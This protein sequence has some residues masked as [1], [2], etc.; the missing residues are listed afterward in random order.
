MQTNGAVCVSDLRSY[1]HNTWATAAT[2]PVY[3]DLSA[4]SPEGTLSIRGGG[5]GKLN[6]T[7]IDPDHRNIQLDFPNLKLDLR[8][9]PDQTASAS[10]T[11]TYTGVLTTGNSLVFVANIPTS[12]GPSYHLLIAYEAVK[13][14][15]WQMPYFALVSDLQWYLNSTPETVS[16]MARR[17]LVWAASARH[18]PY[19]VPPKFRKQLPDGTIAEVTAV[20]FLNEYPFC[21]WDGEGQ[22]IDADQDVF[23]TQRNLDRPAYSEIAVLGPGGDFNNAFPLGRSKGAYYPNFMM[24]GDYLSMGHSGHASFWA[25][26]GPWTQ[27]GQITPGGSIVESGITYNLIDVTG[28][29]PEQIV[30]NLQPNTTGGDAIVLT[31]VLNDGREIGSLYPNEILG[32]R[33]YNPP[34]EFT[35]IDPKDIKFFHVWKRQRQLVTF[36]GLPTVPAVTPEDNP[37]PG[38]VA[39][40]LAKLNMPQENPSTQPTR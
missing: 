21:W 34:S 27:I 29:P 26:F 4:K 36:S 15:D 37:T 19:T 28:A 39:A 20:N 9:S 14:P 13:L 16:A 3:L 30:A 38:E 12:P 2:A 17:A 5:S 7:L 40:A 22:P 10:L 32:K 33:D 1:S 23:Y 25:P 8:D 24:H 35:G 31:A 18:D 6:S 11:L